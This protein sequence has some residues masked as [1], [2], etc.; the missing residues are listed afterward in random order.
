MGKSELTQP[1]APKAVDHP[2]PIL[3]AAEKQAKEQRLR[4]NQ[5][6]ADRGKAILNKH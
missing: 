2:Q 5:R 1:F 6:E 4:D 3:T